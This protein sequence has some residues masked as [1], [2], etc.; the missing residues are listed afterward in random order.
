MYWLPILAI[1]C[2]AVS[3]YYY[4]RVIQAMYF[5]EAGEGSAVTPAFKGSFKVLMIVCA[6][7][8]LALGI[9]PDWLMDL[10]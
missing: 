8:I 1:I 6:V 2:A 10:L 5:R 4:F 9:H 3:V 7:L